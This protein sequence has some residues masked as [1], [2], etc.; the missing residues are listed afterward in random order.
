MTATEWFMESIWNYLQ[1]KTGQIATMLIEVINNGLCTKSCNVMMA[2]NQSQNNYKVW[3]LSMCITHV[4]HVYTLGSEINVPP[5]IKVPPG[6]LDKKNKRAPSIIKL[7]C[8]KIAIL[9][10]YGSYFI[11]KMHFF[12][13]N[14]SLWS[15]IR[16]MPPGKISEN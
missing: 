7:L 14:S 1:N 4:K 10:A 9:A 15:G 13:Q 12:W 16:S 3:G 2:H 8:K 6:T 11:Q 5:G